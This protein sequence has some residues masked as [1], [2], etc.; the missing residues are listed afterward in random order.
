[1]TSSSKFWLGF[2]SFVLVVVVIFG[3]SGMT[4]RDVKHFGTPRNALTIDGET[5]KIPFPEPG[6]ERL[7]PEVTPTTS[8]EY[9]F[10]NVVAGEPVR[11]DPCRPV[12]YVINPVGAPPGSDE[13]IFEAVEIV[14]ESTGLLF[15]FEGYTSEVASFDRDLI[16]EEFYGDRFVPLIFGWSTEVH[17]SELEGSVAGLGGSTSTAG[18]YGDQQYLVAGTVILDGPD[19]QTMMTTS[20]RRPL[21]LAVIMHEIGHVVGLGHVDDPGELMNPTNSS[22]TGWGPGDLEGLAVAGRGVCQQV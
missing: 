11:W 17:E 21:A 20:G 2:L 4:W 14:S 12:Y 13:L 9:A 7:L 8:G 6:D 18:A 16:Q 10:M 22:L 19:L 1:M 3:L 5:V 15:E